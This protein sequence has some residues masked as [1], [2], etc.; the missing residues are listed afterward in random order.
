LEGHLEIVMIF[1][2][3]DQMIF[4]NYF[5]FY[6]FQCFLQYQFKNRYRLIKTAVKSRRKILKKQV[7]IIL[8]ILLSRV[9]LKIQRQTRSC[10]IKVT[11]LGR[12]YF[13]IVVCKVWRVFLRTLL[14]GSWRWVVICVYVMYGIFFNLFGDLDC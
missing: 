6:W 5:Y 3:I 1:R 8:F 4:K 10:L 7:F 12:C 9:I 13:S 11:M 2:E 14:F